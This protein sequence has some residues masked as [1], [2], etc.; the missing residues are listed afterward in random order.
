MILSETL[1][2]IAQYGFP[3]VVAVWFM[4]R[5]ETTLDKNRAI[6]SNNTKAVNKLAYIIDK[7]FP[8]SK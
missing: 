1:L 4:F 3:I 2:L 6:I 8:K 5:L 7:H